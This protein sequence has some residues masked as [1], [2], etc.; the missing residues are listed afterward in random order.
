VTL[1]STAE[2]IK[3]VLVILEITISLIYWLPL[4][5]VIYANTP[6]GPLTHELCVH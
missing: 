1:K 6:P 2:P 4:H 5:Y 3:L